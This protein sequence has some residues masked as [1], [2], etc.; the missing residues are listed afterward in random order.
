MNYRFVVL[1]DEAVISKIRMFLSRRKVASVYSLKKGYVMFEGEE[2]CSELIAKYSELSV[3]KL[4]PVT[5]AGNDADT[6]RP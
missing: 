3:Y 2:I 4:E 6:K 1:S 5:A